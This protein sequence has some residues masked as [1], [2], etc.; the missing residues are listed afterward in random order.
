MHSVCCEKQ[1]RRLLV[2]TCGTNLKG[3]F[4][5]S[6]LAERQTIARLAAFG[7]RLADREELLGPC[8]ECE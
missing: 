7:N 6:E 1:A 2:S 3:E 8:K 5:A 4:V